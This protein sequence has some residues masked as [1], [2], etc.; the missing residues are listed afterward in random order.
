MIFVFSIFI[1]TEA[2]RRHSVGKVG[3]TFA[4]TTTQRANVE[5][6]SFHGMSTQDFCTLES[7]TTVFHQCSADITRLSLC[8]V[9]ESFMLS[10]L[11][12]TD[13]YWQ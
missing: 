4:R 6:T 3:Y 1:G 13:R 2:L 10:T 5:L 7:P 8:T 9:D 12:E 11:V